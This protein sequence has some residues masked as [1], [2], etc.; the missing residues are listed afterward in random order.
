L[1]WISSEEP[2]QN[3]DHGIA[4]D[5]VDLFL[6]V[7]PSDLKNENPALILPESNTDV[8][9]KVCRFI[10][11]NYCGKITSKDISRMASFS[12]RQISRAFKA[13]TGLTVFE[14]LRVYRML[15]ASINLNMTNSKIISVAYDCGYDT[16]SSFFTDFKKLF[17][18]SPAEFRNRH[19]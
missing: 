4:K 13:D 7:L 18:L 17:S 16:I 8:S 2:L 10:E 15:Q 14:Y 19:R 12:F 1:Q 9:R 3:L 5:C 6:K 11:E